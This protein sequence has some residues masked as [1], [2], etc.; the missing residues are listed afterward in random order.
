MTHIKVIEESSIAPRVDVEVID[1]DYNR[2]A[3]GMARNDLRQFIDQ[4]R[5]F[6]SVIL[7]QDNR[8]VQLCATPGCSSLVRTRST[9]HICTRC[10]D[11][12]SYGLNCAIGPCHACE[13]LTRAK[14][15]N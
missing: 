3:V 12:D 10:L 8:L 1:T 2:V 14:C 6:D 11:P 9:V 7:W 4:A 5:Q 13:P 15:E